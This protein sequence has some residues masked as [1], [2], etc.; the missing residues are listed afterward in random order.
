MTSSVETFRRKVLALVEERG[1][2]RNEPV[3]IRPLGVEEAI[4]DPAPWRDYPLMEGKEKLVEATYRSGRGQAFTSL[5]AGWKGTLGAILGLPLDS[6]RNRALFTATANALGRHLGLV[7]NTIHCHDAAPGRCAK[8]MADEVADRLGPE[9]KV[10]LVGYQPGFVHALSERLG[11]GR[12]L[13]VD[14]DAERIGKI[15]AGVL[16]LDG[17]TELEHLA[18]E[19]AFALATGSTI[20]NDSLD[21][22]VAAFASRGKRTAF[23]G[24]T[25]ALAAELLGLERLCFEAE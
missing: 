9:G 10:A 25:I 20:V 4:G 7:K 21:E 18:E 19:T 23:F 8:R 24:T 13:V 2:D 22:T 6:D 14:L 16:I 12:L 3:V 17:K 15:E 11:P 1:E 5:P